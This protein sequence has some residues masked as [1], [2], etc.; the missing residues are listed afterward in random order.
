MRHLKPSGVIASHI[1][2]QPPNLIPAVANLVEAH[3]L[4]AHLIG[5]R[6]ETGPAHV[7]YWMLISYRRESLDRPKL[8][9]ATNPVEA[10]AVQVI[11]SQTLSRCCEAASTLTVLQSAIARPMPLYAATIF[12]SAFLLF[13]VQPVIAKQ[14]LPWFG[15]SAAV[16]T[17]CLVFF[18]IALL[19]GYTYSDFVVRRITHRT[20]V[21]LHAA[22]LLLSLAVLPIV[23]AAHWK[24]L[25]SEDP[26]L[27]ILGMLVAT[28]GLPY[29]LLSATSPLVQAWFARARPGASPYRLFALSNAASML[30]LIGYPFLLEPWVPTRG[31][32][33]GWSIAYGLFIALCVAAGWSSLRDKALR[34]KALSEAAPAP[35]PKPGRSKRKKAAAAAPHETGKESPPPN[36]TQ[37]AL[38]AIFAAT[39]AVLLLAVSNHITQNIASVPLLWIFP[40]AIYLSTFILCFDHEGW[41]RRNMF[42]VMLAVALGLMG[43]ALVDEDV[44]YNVSIQ[45]GLFCVGLFIGCMFCHG[46]LVRSKPAPR[47][48]T[49]FYLMIALGGAAGSTLIG[50]VAPLMLPAYFELAGGLA[51]T[52]L[53]LAWQV[54]GDDA[55]FRALGGVVVIATIGCAAWSIRNFY[56][57]TLFATRNFYGVLRVRETGTGN[58]HRRA[59]FHGT[60]QHGL[61]YFDPKLARYPTAY[62]APT[63]GIGRLL[64]Q[65]PGGFAPRRVGV[66]G[67][68]I[69]TLSAYAL[70][71]DVY[72]FYEINP[73]VINLAQR[74]FTYLKETPAT[75]ELALGDA[76]LSL[77]GEPDQGFDVLVVDA[78]NG[79]AIPVHLLTAEALD[80]YKRHMKPGGVIA[81]HVTNLFLN[82]IPVVANLADA[83]H[84]LALHIADQN[85]NLPAFTSDW[86]LLSDRRE[87]LN[88]PR[89]TEAAKPVDARPDWRIWT[90]DFNNI[91]Q[92]L[93]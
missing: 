76:R 22:L 81:I 16:W 89:L 80:I 60:V 59:L 63:S 25:G 13:L 7:S 5:D 84:F 58:S 24:P 35:P 61:Q 51:L 12:V 79:D 65:R 11:S 39:G 91:V 47:Y 70:Q 23:P 15:G 41:Y 29:F 71:G 68:G 53:L 26:P 21:K 49:R 74:D 14:I 9:A 40:L 92:V 46:E 8:T 42:L 78:F 27:R 2:K 3:Y 67:L 88:R 86:M 10:R 32:A 48:L 87:S 1:T 75:I 85:S 37:Q 30:A 62:Y 72:R 17:T 55:L 93:K 4:Y 45:V 34:E 31:Q 77:E 64:S 18:Q 83:R 36:M 54:R 57:D 69:G 73:E 28:I 38:W 44:T 52:A 33:L 82:L 50:I 56:V 90:D 6:N 66:I 20:Q 43:W 19:A